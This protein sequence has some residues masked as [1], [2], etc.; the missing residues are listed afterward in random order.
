MTTA[1]IWI[2]ELVKIQNPEKAKI[3]SG[4]FKTGKG[5]YGE[6]D[7]FIGI[8]VPQNRDIAKKYYS[9]SLNEIKTLLHHPVHEIR[10]SALLALVRKFDRTKDEA[11]QKEIIEFYLNN[12]QYI[13]NWDLV[14]LS[15]YFILGKYLMNREHDILYALS[16]STNLWEQRIAIVTTLAFIRA[17]KFDTALALSLKYLT[18]THDLIHKATGWVLREIGKKDIDV[19]RHFLNTHAQHMPRTTLRYAIEKLHPTERQ[20]YLSL[21]NTIPQQQR[22]GL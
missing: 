7:I 19:L 18:H 15:C 11:S 10:L 14:D 5:Q 2:N 16:D 4:F 20:H 9:S 12:T 22:K 8:T 6:G 1:E 21:K 3:L 13:N 17:G